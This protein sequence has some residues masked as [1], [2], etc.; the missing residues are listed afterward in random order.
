MEIKSIKIS[1]E[2]QRIIDERN[3]AI[4]IAWKYAF[5]ALMIPKEY[6]EQKEKK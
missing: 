6:F 1:K 5:K 2:D 3:K 4:E